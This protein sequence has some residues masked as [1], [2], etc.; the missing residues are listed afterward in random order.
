MTSDLLKN[1]LEAMRV[2]PSSIEGAVRSKDL[3]VH[4]LLGFLFLTSCTSSI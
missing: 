2:V 4:A 3:R 1:S